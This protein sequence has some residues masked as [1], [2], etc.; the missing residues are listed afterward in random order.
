MHV[1]CHFHRSRDT[2]VSSSSSYTKVEKNTAALLVC[3]Q[4]CNR[5][6]K[7]VNESCRS[8]EANFVIKTVLAYAN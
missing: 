6:R 7:V 2:I 1:K 4:D 8:S 5:V 3:C